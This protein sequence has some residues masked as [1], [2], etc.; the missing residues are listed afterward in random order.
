MSEDTR[1]YEDVLNDT[2]VM[3][4]RKLDK[5]GDLTPGEVEILAR[6]ATKREEPKLGGSPVTW[7]QVMEWRHRMIEEETAED[8]ADSEGTG[9][10]IDTHRYIFYPWRRGAMQCG[11]CVSMVPKDL[12]EGHAEFHVNNGE[13]PRPT[14]IQALNATEVWAH[15]TATGW[16]MKSFNRGDVG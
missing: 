6:F 1:S 12:C 15:K 2:T 14:A 16:I 7:D 13:F 8:C 11:L 9:L 4:G 10:G 3:L 5:F